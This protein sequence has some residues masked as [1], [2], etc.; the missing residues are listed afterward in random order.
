MRADGFLAELTGRLRHRRWPFVGIFLCASSGVLLGSGLGWSP[1]VW[2]VVGAAALV[3]PLA[4][5]FGWLLWPGIVCGFAALQAG[6]EQW[7]PGRLLWAET[8]TQVQTARVTGQVLDAPRPVGQ[9]WSFPMRVQFVKTSARAVEAMPAKLMVRWP[10]EPPAFGDVVE[11]NGILR[12]IGPPRN[13][14]EFDFRSWQNRRGIWQEWK[15]RSEADCS[16]LASGKGNPIS[17]TALRTRDW[18]SNLLE[19]GMEGH[20]AAAGLVRAMTLGDT[21]GLD[22][23]MLTNFR[24]TGTLHLFSVSGLHVGMLGVLLW[25]GLKPLR[26]PRVPHILLIIGLLFFYAAITGLRPASVRAAFMA[27][28]VLA[29][30]LI[31]RPAAP[32]NSLAAAGVL[33]L[34]ADTNQLFNP[35]FQLSFLVVF[36]ILLIGVP[37]GNWLRQHAGPDPFLPPKLY[38]KQ[39]HLQAWM[40]VEFGSLAAISFSAWLGSLPLIAWY[41]HL[42]SLS[43]IPVNLIAVPLAFC[44]LAVAMLALVAGSVSLWLAVVFNHTNLLIAGILLGIIQ[45]AAG[46]P[47]SYFRF[48]EISLRPPRAEVV[49]FD[50]GPGG[51][52]G[53]VLPGSA[54]VLDPGSTFHWDRVV[55]TWLHRRGISRLNGLLLTHGDARHIGGAREAIGEF[56]PGFVGLSPLRDRSRT[57]IALQRWME[58]EQIPKRILFAGD[59]FVAAPGWKVEILYPPTGLELPFADDKVL[60]T[61]WS[62][63]GVRML[64]VSDGGLAVEDWLIENAADLL[65]ADILIVGRH[66]SGQPGRAAFLQK[67]KPRVVI[68]SAADFPR[69]ERLPPEWEKLVAAEGAELFRQDKTGAVLIRVFPQRI[70]VSSFLGARQMFEWKLED[71]KRQ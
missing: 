49:V 26:L 25:F 11:G 32:L 36:S 14:G 69:S 40:A 48:G 6:G 43:A 56:R 13:P 8:G 22:E 1:T 42:V 18:I 52:T 29:G 23:K 16:V 62:G 21:S 12:E 46:L 33:I 66:I 68:A 50:L 45:F 58:E 5:R 37:V 60:V 19:Q 67:V 57:S 30:L 24:I 53:L 4:G 15:I 9:G 41:Y 39:H 71:S 7:S 3:F 55:S 31:D 44:V 27:A 65:A 20:P 2:L 59:W 35:G 70:E 28:V 54:Y 34:L 38:Q 63:P 61:R 10:G 64:F 17:A 47:G 51:A